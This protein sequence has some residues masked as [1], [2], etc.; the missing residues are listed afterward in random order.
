MAK[1][2]WNVFS[3]PE[4]ISEYLDHLHLSYLPKQAIATIYTDN[5]AIS[6]LSSYCMIALYQRRNFS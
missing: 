3:D 4:H 6:N 5:R 2:L 1:L